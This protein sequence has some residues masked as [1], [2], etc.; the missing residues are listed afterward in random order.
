[1]D[2]GF[3]LVLSSLEIDTSDIQKSGKDSVVVRI[4]VGA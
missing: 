3:V 1:M 4:E 2:F